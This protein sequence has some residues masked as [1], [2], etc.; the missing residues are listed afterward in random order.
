MKS[1]LDWHWLGQKA[2]SWGGGITRDMDSGGTPR[3]EYSSKEIIILFRYLK[4]AG[5]VLT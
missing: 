1:G 3:G 4:A 2:S 5:G